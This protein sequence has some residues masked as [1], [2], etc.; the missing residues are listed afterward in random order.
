MPNKTIPITIIILLIAIITITAGL[1]YLS[2]LFIPRPAPSDQVSVATTIFPLA[3]IARNIAGDNINIIQ[4][5]PPGTSPH[6]YNLTPQKLAEIQNAS[7]LFAIGHGLD[8]QTI[9][10][11]TKATNIPVVI[12]DQNIPLRHFENDQD[13]SRQ[14]I[15]PHYWLTVP[16]AKTIAGTIASTFQQI[17]PQNSDRYAGNLVAY[18]EQL[19]Q[20]EQELQDKAAAANNKKFIAIHNAW[21]YFAG[22]Y[23]LELLTTYEPVEGKQPSLTDIQQLQSIIQQH[24]ISAF[25]TEPQ[26][27][28]TSA[29]RFLKE[30]LGLQIKILDPIGGLNDYNSYFNLMRQNLNSIIN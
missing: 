27:Q 18:S 21:S 10:A 26:K 29:T 4:V 30:D 8:D 5:L 25:H 19:D 12:V 17:D 13:H 23:G 9:Q 22:H 15:D 14:S 6:T 11:V 1:P 2:S 28:S 16:N 7:A 20:L 24:N 3:D